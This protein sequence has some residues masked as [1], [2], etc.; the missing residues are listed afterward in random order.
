[1]NYAQE[2]YMNR[3]LHDYNRLMNLTHYC[4]GEKIL[5]PSCFCPAVPTP[6]FRQFEDKAFW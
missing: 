5:S 4:W 6:L 2:F 1:M 3:D